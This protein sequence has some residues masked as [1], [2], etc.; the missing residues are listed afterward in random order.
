VDYV[1]LLVHSLCVHLW[2]GK[3][4]DPLSAADLRKH[5]KDNVDEKYFWGT[6]IHTLHVDSGDTDQ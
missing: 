3:Y 4:F 1:L 2:I 6:F 5:S